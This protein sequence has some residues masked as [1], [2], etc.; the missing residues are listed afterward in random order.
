MQFPLARST[1]RAVIA[2]ALAA[3]VLVWLAM[4]V[5]RLRE[6]ARSAQCACHL[7]QLELALHNYESAYGFLPPAAITDA[8]GKPLLSWRVAILP[9]IG[10][11]R[12]YKQIKLD[13]PWDSADNRKFH[14]QM[15]EN[16]GCPSRID[17]ASEG[18]T[19]YVAVVGPRSVFPGGDKARRR[20]D[21]RDDPASTLM[22]VES[23]NCAINWMEP[24]DLEWDRMSFRLNDPSR[25]SLSSNHHSGSYPGPHVILAG[26]QHD[27]DHQ[28]VTSLGAAMSPETVKSLLM[29]DYGKKTILRRSP[30]LE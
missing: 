1:I 2:V 3:P 23:K 15:P 22:V 17:N 14:A 29:I 10:E 18:Y 11:E 9:F 7:G 28:V 5:S 6:E 26:H 21:I 24:R 27:P 8:T 30:R 16:F 13:E 20:S 12:L 25:P 19:D 4:T